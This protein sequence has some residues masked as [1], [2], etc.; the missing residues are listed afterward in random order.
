M[1]GNVEPLIQVR[2][3]LRGLPD[4]VPHGHAR[5]HGRDA[6]G[7]L[8]GPKWSNFQTCPKVDVSFH[9]CAEGSKALPEYSVATQ[10]GPHQLWGKF[11]IDQLTA[12]F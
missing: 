2:K 7:G 4:A 1:L 9:E 12:E 10:S 3:W 5:H 11:K 8:R 6:Q